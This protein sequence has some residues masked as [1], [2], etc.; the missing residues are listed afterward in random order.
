MKH[1]LTTAIFFI[2]ITAAAAQRD[3]LAG[4]VRYYSNIDTT[5]SGKLRY[6]KIS[7]TVNK[8]TARTLW[9]DTLDV[10]KGPTVLQ[11]YADSILQVYR[12][13]SLAAAIDAEYYYYKYCEHNT[14]LQNAKNIMLKLW[15][16]RPD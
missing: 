2:L 16:I 15:A 1:I 4:E 12:Y 11:T 9:Y 6:I 7:Y 3:T 5:A 14:R 10:T 8:K 13:D